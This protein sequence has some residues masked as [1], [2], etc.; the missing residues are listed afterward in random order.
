MEHDLQVSYITRK[1]SVGKLTRGRG[2][3]GCATRKR[4]RPTCTFLF[5]AGAPRL[6][7]C[8]TWE[9]CS[10]YREERTSVLRPVGGWLCAGWRDQVE[11]VKCKARGKGFSSISAWVLTV[12]PARISE[13]ALRNYITERK[14][15][16][17]AIR[18]ILNSLLRLHF[19]VTLFL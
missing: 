17:S 18:V 2:G 6:T 12:T 16:T 15:Q 8:A 9:P 3:E 13:I 5:D 1:Y 7:C 14:R 11:L 4:A 10:R 19:A